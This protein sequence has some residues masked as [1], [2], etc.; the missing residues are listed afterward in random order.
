MNSK[1]NQKTQKIQGSRI[2][3]STGEKIFDS[4]NVIFLAIFSFTTFYPFWYVLIRS[5]N[6]GR[7]ALK[8]GIWFL[9]REFT[10]ENYT[11]AFNDARIF[12]S[13]GVSVFITVALIVLSLFFTCMVAY[14]MSIKYFPG[15][16]L[17]AFYWYFTTMFGGGMIPYFLLLRTLGLNKSIW[18]YIIPEIYSF[19]KFIM[20]RTYF[21]NIPYEL[22][23]SAEMDGAGH[24]K[25]MMKIYMPLAKPMLATQG[26]MI[27]VSQ[28]NSWYTG[29]YYQAKAELQPAASVLKMMMTE[30]TASLAEAEAK[31][32]VIRLGKMVTYTSESIQYAFVMILTIPIIIAYPFVQKYFV[33]GMLVGSVKG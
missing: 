12:R 2:K 4:V 21:Q 17:F 24:L 26:L 9:P 20:I 29:V 33:K 5:L 11:F 32:D 8:G 23:E 3:R 10:W 19:S 13:L 1:K 30:A 28:W 18:L 6:T 25:T 31:G 7:D 16:S 22:R 27:G 15:R 14:A